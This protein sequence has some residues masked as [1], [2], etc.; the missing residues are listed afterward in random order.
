[1]SLQEDCSRIEV[2][3]VWADGRLVE[4]VASQPDQKAGPWLC[5]FKQGTPLA[6][7]FDQESWM[8]FE[9]LT[10]DFQNLSPL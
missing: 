4:E 8:G 1:M 3:L 5:Q 6:P 2:E 7:I 9:A 10:M